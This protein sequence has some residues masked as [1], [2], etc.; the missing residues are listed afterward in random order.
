MA[1]CLAEWPNLLIKLYLSNEKH[2]LEQTREKANEL[3]P[4]TASNCLRS[5]AM[6]VARLSPLG[7]TSPS[8]HTVV[9]LEAKPLHS[10]MIEPTNSIVRRL[11]GVFSI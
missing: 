10:L 6:L 5:W 7:L 1:G 2:L 11:P 8:S 4:S 3:N 9:F